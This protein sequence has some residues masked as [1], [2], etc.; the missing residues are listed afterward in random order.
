MSTQ[1]DSSIFLP[2]HIHDKLTVSQYEGTGWSEGSHMGAH[3]EVHSHSFVSHPI[4]VRKQ[5]LF[6]F[7]V[8]TCFMLLLIRVGYLQ[9]VQGVSFR[10]IAEGNRQRIVPIPSAR[11]LIFDTHGVEL[12]KNVPS[13]SLALIPQDLPRDIEERRMLINRLAVLVGTS[14]ES[15]AESIN[16][17]GSYSYESISIVEDLDYD[18]A[19]RIYIAASDMPGI[20]IH[21][22][23]KRLYVQ[24]SNEK[25]SPLPQSMSHILGYLGKLSP[26]ELQV[27]YAKGYLPVDTIGKSGIESQYETALRGTYGRRS[28]EVD[29][30]GK[31]Q[32]VLVEEAPV[33][34]N[35]ITLTVDIE[36]Q[37][38]LE[39]IMKQALER[40]GFSRA[41][42]IAMD[43]RDGSVLAM[44]SL[45]SFD[46]NDFSGGISYDAYQSYLTNENRPLFNRAISGAYP[47][48]STIKPAIAAAA[49]EE[50]VITAQ[51]SFLSTGGIQVGPWFFPDWQAGGHGN[52][53]VR[54]SI[55][56]SVN[57]FYYFIG[58]GYKD[59]V[60]LGV[61]RI[62]AR[63]RDF[64]FASVVG[65]DIPGEVPGFLPS[66]AWK[67]QVKGERWYV[68]DTYNLSIGQ[69]DVLVTPLQLTTYIASIANGGTLYRPHLLK[70]TTNTTL[71][72]D[73]PVKPEIIREIPITKTN[74]ETV[75][76]GMK[77]CVE[78]GS[79]RRLSLLPFSAG[80][81]SGTAQW[82]STKEPHAWFTAFAPYENPQIVFTILVEEGVGGSDTGAPIAFEFLNWWWKYQHGALDEQQ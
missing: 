51:T 66:R 49:L 48:G 13:F 78:Y 65:I 36:Q 35:H 38:A 39:Q 8:L 52:T 15:I 74:I 17:Y 44:V 70:K 46:N 16:K 1:K 24:E 23:S 3:T 40:G 32:K 54:R 75:R 73:V 31:E 62:I 61:D 71:D 77:D 18:T 27:L 79:C 21:R 69:G 37:S 60:G 45:P 47:S 22:G 63:L 41:V 58:G 50:G 56:W 34:G 6:L 68:G 4:S 43:P 11:G 20:S 10:A 2:T 5:R 7:F 82:N 67:E 14:P 28:I 64:N 30:L 55:A 25:E 72:T 76:L 57:T 29:A 33:D 80:G 26:E 59:F 19:L 81:K 9:I 12:T 53:D 42:G